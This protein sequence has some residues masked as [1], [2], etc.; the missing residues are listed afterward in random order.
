MT[1]ALGV[2]ARQAIHPVPGEMTVCSHSVP[3]ESPQ[4]CR[5]T[6]LTEA[7]TV[8]YSPLLATYAERQM[9]QE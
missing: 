8:I 9:S 7:V 4:H 6:S 2:T 3:E 1:V 5:E